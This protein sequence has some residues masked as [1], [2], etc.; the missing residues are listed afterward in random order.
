MTEEQTTKLSRDQLYNEIW[1]M[2][3]SGVAKKYNVPYAELLKLCKVTDIPYPPSGY[4]T[5]LNYGKTV[6]KTPLPESSIIEVTLPAN[7]APKRSK[8]TAASAGLTEVMKDT[9]LVESVDSEVKVAEASEVSGKQPVVGVSDTPQDNQ[10]TYRTV[11]GKRNI[12][13]RG[14]L[15]EEVW[16]KPVVDVA[17][18]YGVSDVAI[19]KI[20][21]SLNVLC[22]PVAT[23]QGFVLG[24]NLKGPRSQKQTES[25]R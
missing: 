10:L 6:T 12:Y 17:V 14:K 2:S 9:Q 24:K 25:R 19:H 5:Q 8:R 15:Y 21:K 16:A 22:H 11:D 4:W 1:E 23:G 20:C 18:Q 7:F 13:N 3:V